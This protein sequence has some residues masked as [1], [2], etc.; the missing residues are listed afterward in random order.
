MYTL[1]DIQGI[2][3]HSINQGLHPTRHIAGN[4]QTTF[5]ANVQDL[6]AVLLAAMN[7]T[8]FD[9]ILSHASPSPRSGNIEM[10]ISMRGMQRPNGTS[11]DVRTPH[12]PNSQPITAINLVFS[13]RNP[14]RIVTVV[15]YNFINMDK[16]RNLGEVLT[17]PN[18]RVAAYQ[19]IETA[20]EAGDRPC[21]DHGGLLG[22]V[23][24]AGA[25]NKKNALGE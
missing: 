7:H 25:S 11:I 24:T 2:I 23:G 5:F 1:Q 13:S 12:F 3:F 21:A 19:Y 20:R 18:R 16:G 10:T 17:V 4:H 8:G 9:Y 14:V 6:E 15:P 22:V